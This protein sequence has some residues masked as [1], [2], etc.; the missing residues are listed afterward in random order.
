[1]VALPNL[2]REHCWLFLERRCVPADQTTDK[3][4]ARLSRPRDA[5][6]AIDDVIDGSSHAA[7]IDDA[8]LNA[9]RKQFPEHITKVKTLLRSEEFPCAVIAYNP[10]A[11]SE[12]LLEQ[13]RTGLLSAKESSRGRQMM[14]MCRITSFEDVPDDFDK[15]LEAIA[16]A[17]P[18]PVK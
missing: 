9:Y 15:T 4:Y 1:M 12:S 8:D 7:V 10:G 5:S 14:Q 11:L 3:F 13:F 2:S 18:P 17:Y 16:K 6:N